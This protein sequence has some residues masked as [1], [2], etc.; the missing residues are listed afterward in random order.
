MVLQAS[1]RLSGWTSR[2]EHGK[3]KRHRRRGEAVTL[4]VTRRYRVVWPP[5]GVRREMV[6]TLSWDH[7]IQLPDQKRAF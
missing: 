4:C 3:E 2:L 6:V 5:R 7:T 1:L